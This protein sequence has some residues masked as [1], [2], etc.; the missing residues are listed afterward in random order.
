MAT[1]TSGTIPSTAQ[2]RPCWECSRP[3]APQQAART[4]HGW[5]A[6]ICAHCEPWVAALIG[7]IPA[8]DA[9]RRDTR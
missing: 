9:Q 1:P 2:N 6:I 3:V 8:G 4:L 5:Q 7:P